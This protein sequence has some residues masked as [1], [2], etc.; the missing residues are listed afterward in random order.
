[1]RETERAQEKGHMGTLV[2]SAQFFCELKIALKIKHINLKIS[3]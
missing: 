3:K 1:M 2:L